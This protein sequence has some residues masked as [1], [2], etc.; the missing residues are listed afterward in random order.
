MPMIDVTFVRG[1]VD[2]DAL[3]RL[4]DELVTV[5]LRTERAPDTRFCVTTRGCIYTR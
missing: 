1:S 3:N 2:Q 5:L 4:A